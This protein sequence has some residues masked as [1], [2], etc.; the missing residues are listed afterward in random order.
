MRR[1]VMRRWV[2][3]ALYTALCVALG[4]ASVGCDDEAEGAG[5]DN[6][7][8]PADSAGAND[9]QGA[10]T[11]DSAATEEDASADS[12]D[13]ATTPPPAPT[14]PPLDAPVDAPATWPPCQ[15]DRRP[16][17]FAHGFLSSGDNFAL[18]A[19]RLVSN[20]H[21]PQAIYAFDWDTLAGNAEAA[22]S[23]LD[24]VIDRALAEHGADQV[25]LIGHSAGGGLGMTYLAEPDRAA[26]VAHY[27]HVGSNTQG[28]SA[29]QGVAT[30][31]LTSAADLVVQT[32]AEDEVLGAQ[33]VRLTDADHLE[34]LT[35]ADAFE[36][37]FE[38]FYG[39]RPQTTAVVPTA[40]VLLGGRALALGTNAPLAEGRV[41]AYPL[42]P[43]TG[44]RLS[45]TPQASLAT[46]ASGH[47]GPFVATP[48]APYELVVTG[49]REARPVRYYVEPFTTSS[50]LVYL[51]TFPR[52]PS[53]TGILLRDLPFDD[54]QAIAVTFT[55]NQAVIAGR[56]A[57][58]FEG[59]TL[60]SPELAAAE[61]S[62]IALFLF[63]E[64]KN[65][66]TDA[67]LAQGAFAALPVFLG[68]LD[69]SIPADP[70]RAVTATFNGSTLK[71]PAWPSRTEGAIV[72][73]FR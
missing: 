20:G 19:Q 28:R 43:A 1:Q 38:A 9:T 51:R 35:N 40:E 59:V 56:D 52:P 14:I 54:A 48:G 3:A 64:N 12:G 31:S 58:T 7:A 30:L 62:L 29:P 69:V 71:A 17:V 42:D 57:L 11:E 67:T 45:D 72:M 37:I 18:Q 50:H 13:D 8:N 66:Q 15:T 6:T 24:A 46:D 73:I 39:E 70:A 49:P 22:A 55:A 21:C 61:R 4:G 33:N 23:A 63:D 41:Y 32:A 36:A 44:Q 26:K 27:A 2:R 16:L 5:A 60:S 25:D 68:G 34:V 47:W 10:T 53:L 65:Q